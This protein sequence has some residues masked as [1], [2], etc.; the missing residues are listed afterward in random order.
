TAEIYQQVNALSGIEDS[1]AVGKLSQQSEEIWLFVKLSQSVELTP[2]LTDL[3][4]QTL[5]T[6]CSPRHVPR[7]I[8]ALSDIP[9]TRSGKTVE[10]AVKQVVNGQT[11]KNIGAIANPEVL[12][13][14]A[15]IAVETQPVLTNAL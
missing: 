4:R 1:I 7:K 5:K 12:E 2:Q 10:L 15:A 11:V 14:I 8:F 9:R 13:E 3:I 6:K